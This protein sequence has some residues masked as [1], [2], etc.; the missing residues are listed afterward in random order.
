[1]ET[2]AAA[3]PNAPHPHQGIIPKFIDPSPALI[4]PEEKETLVSGKPVYQQTRYNDID[5]GTAIFDVAASQKTIW[6]VITSFQNYP[7]WIKE[8]SAT[9]IYLSEEQYILVDFTLSVYLVDVQYYIKHD[10]QPNKGTMTWTLDYNRKSDLNDSAGHWLVY[11][12]P[13]DTAKTRVEYSVALI[14][15]PAIPSFIETI[16]TDKGIKNATNWVKK[17]AEKSASP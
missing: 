2:A 4:S 5:R 16:L 10:Y 14:I 9:E 17:N 6:E 12:S 13:A 3:D 8:I 15:G 1:M 11:T 7:E